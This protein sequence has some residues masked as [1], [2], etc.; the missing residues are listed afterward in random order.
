VSARICGYPAASGSKT[1][2]TA[3]SVMQAVSKTG[4]IDMRRQLVLDDR[5]N[6]RAVLLGGAVADVGAEPLVHRWP[7]TMARVSTLIAR[8]FHVRLPAASRRACTWVRSPL[9][10]PPLQQ[11]S[12]S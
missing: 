11:P 10:Q 9:Q 1:L 3:L 5:G 8:L 7:W 2:S 4:E 6:H 12:V